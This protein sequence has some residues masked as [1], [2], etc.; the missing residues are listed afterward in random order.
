MKISASVDDGCKLDAKLARL[1]E[2]YGIEAT[3]YWPVDFIT[4]S[5]LKGWE[6]LSPGEESY[7][8][9]N[10]EIGSHGV[11]HAYLTKIPEEVAIDEIQDS[12]VMLRTKYNQPI[13]K[14]CYPRG[15]T[16]DRLKQ[17]VK[18]AG[19][20]LAR[21]TEIG[22]IGKPDDPYFAPSAVHIGCPVRPEY[23]D[24][25]WL[26][27]GLKLFA[28][29][30]KRDLDFH[31]WCHSWE[32]EKYNEWGNVKYFLREVSRWTMSKTCVRKY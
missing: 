10:F 5:I 26:D 12:R 6:P 14:F 28:G 13:T 16:N 15:Y 9:K 17:V 11:T 1:F 8:A 22:H 18:D 7:I 30:K 24:T 21:S 19:Y 2:K 25:T 23:K 31:F 4:L 20:E 32:I 3:F 29:A 27:Y